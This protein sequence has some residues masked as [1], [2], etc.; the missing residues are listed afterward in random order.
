MST[1]AVEL[2]EHVE[3]AAFFAPSV[4]RHDSVLAAMLAERADHY[5]EH[6]KHFAK[7]AEAHGGEVSFETIRDYFRDL[8]AA[9]CSANTK[10]IRR[11][12]VKARLRAALRDGMDFNKAA[13]F[14]EALSRLDK[15]SETRAPKVQS[16]AVGTDKIIRRD[17]YDRLI[18]AASYRD[19]LLL[20]FLWTTGCRVSEL[21]GALVERCEVKGK[22]VHVPVTGKGNK[23]RVLRI[24]VALFDAIREEFKGTVYL[25]ETTNGRPFS[26]VYVSTRIHKLALA[27]L[28][29]RLGAHSLRHSFATRQI[30]RTNK[31][32]AVS[33]YLG[34]SSVAITMNFYTH[35]QLED[36]ELFDPEDGE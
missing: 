10:R 18:M 19:E 21:T 1:A 34:H 5:G 31:I 22:T 36:D 2:Q 30:R 4:V 35:E 6:L 8:N 33:S 29:R 15:D 7:Y 11:Q 17:E 3:E 24:R 13:Q 26:R 27:V 12:A 23:E 32:Q 20:D 28:G 9:P 16:A 25:F 14:R